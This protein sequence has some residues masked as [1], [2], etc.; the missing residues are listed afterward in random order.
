MKNIVF[1]YNILYII[2]YNKNIV[3]FNWNKLVIILDK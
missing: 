2:I 3:A 1:I